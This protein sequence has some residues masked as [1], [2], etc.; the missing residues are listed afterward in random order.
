M[1]IVRYRLK[2]DDRIGMIQDVVQVISRE[3]ISINAMEVS[4]GQIFIKFILD[5]GNKSEKALR[6]I[7]INQAD[8]IEV[9]EIALLPQEEKEKELQAILESANNG[10]VG[11]DRTG[12]VRYINS[13]ATKLL[14]IG[15]REAVGRN[16]GEIVGKDDAFLNLLK[17]QP[18][19]NREILSDTIRGRLHHLCSGRPVRD[20]IGEIIGAVIT[21]TSMKAARQLVNS[22]SK[23]D[24]F[25]FEDIIHI[26]ALMGQVINTARQTADST[27][28][29]LI[30]G[31]SGTGKELFARAIHEA[32][33]RRDK[34]FIPINCAAL[35]EALLESELFGY[36]EGAFSGAIKGGKIGLFEA[37]H[38][39]TL[40]LDEIGE[41]PFVLQGKLLRTIQEGM[42]RRVGGSRQIPV[43]VRLL[44]ATNRDL[45]EMVAAKQFRS[46]LFYRVNVIPITVPSLRERPE[47]IPILLR[48]FL[49]KYCT[50][51]N[52]D[53]DFSPDAIRLLIRHDWPGNVREL[54]N[55]VLRAVHLTAGNV[56]ETF[57]LLIARMTDV[58]AAFSQAGTK[59]KAN[60]GDTEKI[61]LERA[62]LKHGSAR[63]AAK[64]LGFSHTAIL[65]KTRRLGLEDL[66]KYKRANASGKTGTPEQ[67]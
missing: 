32:S 14:Q 8:V 20:E 54:Q 55:V 16:I 36:E 35:P 34:P 51:L 29:I 67:L 17:G 66:L 49:A 53:L 45:E 40:F 19:D 5:D 23:K 46:D 61:V 13:T 26:S 56:I 65:K 9:A 4:A 10:I 2:T 47:D 43:D 30:R 27:C 38:Q 21:L 11:L 22:I 60:M 28:T 31:E 3:H 50:E 42:V 62:L 18:F 6:E 64:E 59:F 24:V 12:S 7:L 52:R 41:L 48:Y 63:K 25:R 57:S 44:A 37:A 58:G 1:G 33:S 15:S 39:G